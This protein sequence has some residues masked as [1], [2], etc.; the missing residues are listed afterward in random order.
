MAGILT[1]IKLK[2]A[3]ITEF[4]VYEKADGVGGTWRENT[5]P[6]LACDVPSHLY[7]Y[8]F[9][10]TPAW[11]HRFSPGPEIYAYFER[12]AREHD[13][14]PRIR[15]GEEVTACR[16]GGGRWHLTTAS[17]T[18]DEVDVVIAATGV[19]HHPRYPDIEGLDRFEGACFHSARWDHSVD[20]EGK[21]VGVIG[22]G[23]TAVQITSA[24]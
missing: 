1:A 2:E 11:S 14:L 24:I 15:F 4:T 3:G 22:T 8:S 10:L 21:R 9:A 7:S 23:S 20:I 18:R 19:L 16:F 13:V 12:V 17:G 5:Y 6:G